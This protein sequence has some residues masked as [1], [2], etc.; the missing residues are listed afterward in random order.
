MLFNSHIFR[1]DLNK[2][3][4]LLHESIHIEIFLYN[5]ILH[6]LKIKLHIS[7]INKY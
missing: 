3:L 2:Y 6:I 1:Q 4:N 5:T 7:Y